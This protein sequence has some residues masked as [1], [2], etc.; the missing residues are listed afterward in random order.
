MSRFLILIAIAGTLVSSCKK[1]KS[2]TPKEEEKITTEFANGL[3]GNFTEINGYMYAEYYYQQSSA[4]LY[5]F[6]GF[7][8]PAR[9]MMTCYNKANHFVNFSSQSDIPNIS[10]NGLSFNSTAV[11]TS[12]NSGFS[13]FY[14]SSLFYSSSPPINPPFG[15][16]WA[17]G[18]NGPFV[19]FN[20]T[21]P[22][23]FPVYT[24]VANFPTS[25]SKSAGISFNVSSIVGNF[26]SLYV[27]ISNFSSSSSSG[28]KVKI[29]KNTPT[30]TFSSAS[31]NSFLSTGSGYLTFTAFNY[32]NRTILN[33]KYVYELATV[34]TTYIT[35][36]N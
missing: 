9:N 14:N 16:N 18:G 30:I 27:N 34:N 1:K 33:K 29:D 4:Q 25:V 35:I 7:A 21:V 5:L 6:G 11:Q 28:V 3:P 22:R 32:S 8:D 12:S 10:V 15:A 2:E 24:D 13:F 19:Q 20:Q 36:N 31:L 23:G 26:D 17:I